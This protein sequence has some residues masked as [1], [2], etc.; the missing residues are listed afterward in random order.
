MKI[1]DPHLHLFNL[2][3]GDYAWLR[4]GNA[5]FWADKE[6]INQS[7]YEQDLTL[8]PQPSS[9]PLPLAGFVHIEAGFD[10]VKPWREIQWL[11][12]H[13]QLPFRSIASLNLTL[14]TIA[15][16]QQIKKLTEYKSVVGGR[17]IFDDQAVDLL[18]NP[19]VQINLTCLAKYNLLFE[20]QMSLNNA[21]AIALM[22][23]TFINN[24]ILNVIINHAGSPPF[25]DK[26]LAKN[27]LNS[28][29]LSG[30][31]KLSSFKHC[32][33]KCSGWEM[34]ERNYPMSW[35][36]EVIENCITHFGENRVMLASNFP[37]CL[38]TQTYQQT[39]QNNTQLLIEELKFNEKK[40]DALL[41]SNASHW[42]GFDK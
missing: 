22:S 19:Q 36:K 15:F 18:S 9:T 29:W 42:Y 32:A 14:T 1:I 13:C 28:A 39:W 31:E 30:L 27:E 4:S 41:F 24:P 12:S 2:T 35:V 8:A 5:P 34:A 10:N 7:F 20:L 11:E 23:Q 33:I 3:D 40:C 16:E 37:L 38:F 17:H 25:S 6:K 21:E 26:E